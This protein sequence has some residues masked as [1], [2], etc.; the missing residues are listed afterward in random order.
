MHH[1][2]IKPHNKSVQLTRHGTA[3]TTLND[4]K[5]KFTSIFLVFINTLFHCENCADFLQIKMAIREHFKQSL[6]YINHCINLIETDY[7]Q[8]GIH[9]VSFTLIVQTID[10]LNPQSIDPS[11]FL[12]E[13]IEDEIRA[14]T[15]LIDQCVFI[16]RDCPLLE[17]KKHIF[18]LAQAMTELFQ[19]QHR[20]IYPYRKDLI[21]AY[22]GKIDFVKKL[23]ENK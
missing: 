23:D 8:A 15:M 18:L 5:T 19:L 21:P 22:L 11:H 3:E 10:N 14:L 12:I 2:K 16:I 7:S 9:P 4:I 17:P 20:Y 1:N 13:E 6:H